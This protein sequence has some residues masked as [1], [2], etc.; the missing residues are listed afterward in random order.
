[1]ITITNN[2]FINAGT[3]AID[4]FGPAVITGNYLLGGGFNTV[5]AHPDGIWITNAAGPILIQNNFIDWTPAP[6][7]VEPNNDVIRITTELGNVSDLTITGNYLIGATTIIGAGTQGAG[8]FTNI[9]ITNNY[10]GIGGWAETKV[11]GLTESGNIDFDF[12][13][14]IYSTRAWAAYRSAGLVTNTLVTQTA[15]GASISATGA[16]STTLYGG[17]FKSGLVGGAGENII[18]GGAGVQYMGGGSGKNLFTYLAMSD[19]MPWLPDL[20]GNFHVATDVIDLHA[21]NANVLSPEFKNLRFIG[22]AA[23]SS[24]GGEVRVEQDVAHGITIVQANLIS[25]TTAD[26]TIRINGLLNLTAANFVLTTGQYEA[27]IAGSTTVASF[28]STQPALDQVAGGFSIVDTVANVQADL[29]GLQADSAHINAVTLIDGALTV[30]NATFNAD[31]L[32][33]NKVVGGFNVTDTAAHVQANLAALQADAGHINAITATGGPVSVSAATFR[34]DRTALDKVV[35]TVNIADSAANIQAN[36]Q[37][38]Y[39]DAAHIDTVTPTGGVVTVNL[40]TFA[41]EQGFLNKIAGGFAV[42]DT[43]ATIQAGLAGLNAD[44]ANIVAITATSG[45]VTVSNTYFNAHRAT[46]DKISGGFAIA[47]AS[48]NIQSN[49]AALKADGGHIASITSL[50]GRWVTASVGTF[51]TYKNVL[52]KVVG[53]FKIV[54]TAAHVQANLAALEADVGRI[55]TI[56]ASSGKVSANLAT[57]A[58]DKAALDK[59]VGGF[60]VT[61][62]AAHVQANLAALKSDLGHISAITATGG[63]V[64]VSVAAFLADQAVLNKVVGTVNVAD[65]AANI[66]AHL[67]GLQSYNARIATISPTSGAVTVNVATFKAEQSMLNKI[68]GGFKISDTAANVVANLNVLN[69]D[70]VHISGITATGGPVTVAAAYVTFDRDALND[71]VGGFAVADTAGNIK[72]NL[73][74]LNADN[75]HVISITPRSGSGAVSESVADFAAN[76]AV[77]D[78]IVGGFAISDTA[79]NVQANIAALQSDAGAINAIKLTDS[80]AAAPAVISLSASA[81]ASDAATLAEITSPFVLAT[82]SNGT[83]ALIGHGNGL[84]IAVD[85]GDTTVTGGGVHEILDFSPHF[86]STT[87]TDFATHYADYLHDT[88]SLST[89]DFADWST[90]VA[91]GHASG[92]GGTD[93][94]FLAANGDSLTIAGVSLTTFQHPSAALKSDFVFHA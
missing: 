53:G 14:P 24:A 38:L 74:A 76:R 56:T 51:T 19:S 5:G 72:A 9:S 57:F 12:S 79:A 42:S 83:T 77:L 91:D 78:K 63:P 48:V 6:G 86:G 55:A 17:G 46:L 60:N 33:L 66:Q 87:V 11:P 85:A 82:N 7:A 26:L 35:G 65:T 10:V 3:E 93:T 8:T 90:L 67:A 80:T 1:M 94:T 71:I 81:A 13:N 62:T 16:G 69:A 50:Y 84:T 52:D 64:S 36:L 21:I 34:A 20:I 22:S 61:D 68:A 70:A 31:R 88:I 75:A 58:A 28:R 54:D 29:A 30:D 23:F 59:I 37:T 4:L 73:A 25:N 39:A 44:A 49:L 43:V 89:S 2:T 45:T 15:A 40:A 47:D 27:A 18:I 41:A 32:A 92:A